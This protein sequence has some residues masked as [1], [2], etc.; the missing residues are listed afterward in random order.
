MGG[1]IDRLN[2]NKSFPQ[3]FNGQIF[4]ANT[5]PAGSTP[6][7]TDFQNFL[8]GSPQFVFGQSGA[9]PIRG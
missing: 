2:L 1:E 6:A 8:L 7:L 5:P 3:V 4:F 9:V